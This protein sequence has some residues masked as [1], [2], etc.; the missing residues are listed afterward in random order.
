MRI[1]LAAPILVGSSL[2]GVSAQTTNHEACRP[3]GM[4]TM[5]GVNVPWCNAY[6]TNGREKLA[7]GMG[8]RIVGYF[9]GWRVDT[10]EAAGIA[11]LAN[12]IPWK[13]VTHINYAFAHIDD[14]WKVSVGGNVATNPAI[15]K[16][17]PGVAGAEMDP[18]YAY[19][20]HFNLLN[21]YKKAN[22]GVKTLV[23]V[24]G[25]AETGGY[26]DDNGVRHGNGGFYQMCADQGRINTF[27]DSA[28][29]F[30]RQY[31]FDGLDIDYEY[32]TSNQGAG[33]PLDQSVKGSTVA[34]FGQYRQCLMTMRQALHKASAQDGKYYSLTIAAPDSGWLLRGMEAFQVGEFLDY[35][36]I[37]SYDLHGAWDGKVGAQAALYDNNNDPDTSIYS[38][39]L[40][41]LTAD[42]G[43][44]LFRGQVSAGRINIGVPYYTRGWTK[45][46]GGTNGYGGTAN[47]PTPGY[48][49]C[50]VGTNQCGAGAVGID[51]IWHDS[52]NGKEVPAGANPM[53][54]AKNLE[55]GI[56]ALY[57]KKWNITDPLTGTYTRYYDANIVAPWLW[58]PQ[59][60]VFLSTED[61]VSITAKAQYVINNGFG[62]LMIW[63][64]AGDYAF[65]TSKNEYGVGNTMTEAMASIFSGASGYGNKKESSAIQYEPAEGV[66]PIYITYQCTTAEPYPHMGTITFKNAG[67]E[68]LTITDMRF[69]FSNSI[70]TT[71]G[72]PV[73]QGSGQIAVLVG[74]TKTTKGLAPE[75]L[76]GKYTLPLGTGAIPP[77]GTVTG[78]YG[79]GAMPIS[80]MSNVRVQVGGKWYAIA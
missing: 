73:T 63:E 37:M 46:S 61:D 66:L 25:W 38:H 29:Q 70:D 64:L 71:K 36:N 8:R 57:L 6:D 10:T 2:M 35:I 43:A 33:H 67:N 21:K 3:D 31:G 54:H 13:K 34:L 45:V 65:D 50:P 52:E 44:R 9:T 7:N 59:K 27:A 60:S 12:N 26:L 74:T 23:S 14:S 5:P 68:S 20:G 32:P 77:G 48:G 1:S 58:N 80:Q 17:W 69:D 47:G 72:G 4:Y 76:R 62:G 18:A 41:Y 75:I 30:L 49:N 78:N 16:T 51:N 42:W 53:W 79:G 15:G 56:S 11:Y 28:V 24:G 22:P 40:G 55:K 39:G 19:K